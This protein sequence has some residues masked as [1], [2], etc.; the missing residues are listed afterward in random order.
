MY[1]LNI[2][3]SQVVIT[4]TD[5]SYRNNSSR[6]ISVPKYTEVHTRTYSL[7]TLRIAFSTLASTICVLNIDK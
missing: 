5:F 6:I 1:I 2:Y 7:Q 4:K 3:V